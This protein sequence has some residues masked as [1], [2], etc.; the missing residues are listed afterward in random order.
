MDRPDLLSTLWR[1]SGLLFPLVLL[2]A[3]QAEA[4]PV[5]WLDRAAY[6]IP[7][8]WA[9]GIL[10]ACG[11]I[12][13]ASGAIFSAV[14]MGIITASNFMSPSLAIPIAIGACILLYGTMSILI[15][16]TH[17]PSLL[18]TLGFLFIGRGLSELF[19]GAIKCSP[20]FQS[21]CD[22]QL[23]STMPADFS[24]LATSG[25]I[26]YLFELAILLIL[27]WW[28]YGTLSGLRHIA[29][30]MNIQ[31]SRIAGVSTRR[32]YTFAFIAAGS[33]VA[34]GSVV[35]LVEMSGFAPT[36]GW[37]LELY[38]IA[39]AVLGGTRIT[40]GK[41]DPILISLASLLVAAVRV[42]ID[43]QNLPIEL[44]YPTLGV[45]VIVVAVFDS[46]TD[47]RREY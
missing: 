46:W 30:G 14:G 20:L 10:I 31:G 40:G 2:F 27:L 35:R 47:R 13:I 12:D 9:A 43:A 17:I 1:G 3:F 37:G 26:L 42:T 33:L 18:C 23:S 25:K 38:A 39:A 5:T 29:V 44:I 15:N 16:F 36:T 34:Y 21:I 45:A 28:R 41:F 8:A 19:N 4:S 32:V 6:L 11:Q 7:M 24:W 22:Q